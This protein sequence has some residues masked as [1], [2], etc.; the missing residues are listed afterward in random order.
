MEYITLQN[1]EIPVIAEFDVVVCGGGCAG[2]GAAVSAARQG[3]NT[4]V[5]ERLFSLGGMMTGGLMS[6]I[7]ISPTNNSLAVEILHRLDDYQHTHF[8]ESR[9]EVP[10]DPENMK[11]LLDTMVREEDNIEVLF[12]TIVSEVISQNGKINAIII[13]NIEGSQAIKAKYFIDCSG[14]GQLAF[15]AGA[16]YER[17]NELGYG[18]SPTLMFRVANCDIDTLLTY[19]EDNPE[20]FKISYH[21]YSNHKLNPA[22]NR[23]NIQHDTYAHFADFIRFID[24]K[25]EEHPN[26]FSDYAIKILHQ[27][28]LIFLNQPNPNH[29]LVNSTRIQ[30]FRGDNAKELTDSLMEGRRQVEVIFSFMKSYLPGFENAYLF[31][32]GSMLGIRESRRIIGDYIFTQEDVESLRKFDDVIVSNHGGVE[33][34]STKGTGTDIRELDPDEFYH[35]PY[36]AIIARDFSN[37]FMA[38]RCFS[39]TH[40]GLSAARNIAY[41]IALGE[42]AGAAGAYLSNN[43]KDNVRDIDIRWLQ[44]VMKNAI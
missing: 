33:I 21:T 23:Y 6:K 18:S 27:R 2:V 1:R 14:D 4:L 3:A 36:R 19:M 26:V 35:V 12:G 44:Q 7:A 32:T 42:A 34:H 8:L 24:K 40:A 9:P 31:D 43:G 29:V 16:A 5:I 30:N 15:K 41:C 37:L 17:G 39:A 28:G 10:I 20:E 13:E 22:Q 25:I 11:L 38:G